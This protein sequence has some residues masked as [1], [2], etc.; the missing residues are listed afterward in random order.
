MSDKPAGSVCFIVESGTDARLVEGLAARVTLHV[1]ARAIPGG[2]AVSQP[3]EVTIAVAEPGRV[4]FAWRVFRTVVGRPSSESVLVQGYGLAALG[5]NLAARLRRKPC[6]MLVCS[7]VAEYY[8]ARKRPGYSFSRLTLAA[9]NLLGRLNGL[10]GRGY[11]VLSAHL[12]EVVRQYAQT[13]PVRVI[14]VYGVDVS[15][16]ADRPDRPAVRVERGLPAGGQIIFSSSR[17]A[18]EKDTSTLIEAFADLVREGRD[19]HLLHRSGGYREFAA[20]ADRAGVAARVIATDAVDPRRELAL[21]YV[22]SD[23]CVQA[24]HAEGLGFSV[25]ESLACGTPVIVSAVGG[26]V[27][28]VRDGETGWTVPPGDAGALAAALRDVLDRPEEGRRRAAA[29]GAIVRER[30]SS[31]AAFAALA[32]LLTQPVSR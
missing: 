20:E 18:P 12:R 32:E 3:T 7:P 16:F 14:P 19:V 6:W 21:D 25:L 28:T 23:V 10:V 1:L 2:R 22:A 15:R 9:I 13:R 29:G 30:F 5:A 26:L 11:V 31:E 27:E 17:V 4:A 24:S 8:A